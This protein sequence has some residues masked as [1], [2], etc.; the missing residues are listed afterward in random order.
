[1]QTM[2][3]DRMK[4]DASDTSTSPQ[5][6][7]QQSARFPLGSTIV[8]TLTMALLAVT[9]VWGALASNYRAGERLRERNMRELLIAQE[10]SLDLPAIRRGREQYL[11]TCTACHG[12]NGEALPNLGKD[13]RHSEFVAT[14]SDS[15]MRMFMKLGRNTWDAENTTGV[16]MPPKG[17]N[18]MLTDDDL[19]DIVHFLRYLQAEDKAR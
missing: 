16:A 15:Q 17:G 19:V 1:M 18:P 7:V 14:Q 12:P 10:F 3:P 4:A 6:T 13:L 9:T 11:G 5:G 8:A 2:T